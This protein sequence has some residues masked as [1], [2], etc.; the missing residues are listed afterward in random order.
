MQ[1]DSKKRIG[2]LVFSRKRP[3]FDQDWSKIV[4]TCSLGVLDHLDMGPV[5]ADA[6]VFDDPTI[7][8]ALASIQQAKCDALIIIQPS[9]ADGQFAFSIMQQWSG[10]IV[11]W[12]TPERPGDGN[13][14]SCS[15]VGAHLFA[16]IL[17]Q[18][19]HPFE[20]VYGDGEDVKIQADLARA[21]SLATTVS[22]LQRA[23][24]GVIGNHAPGFVDLAADPFLSR[25][26][27][28]I[29]QLSLSLAQYIDRVNAVS[30]ERV[31]QDVK[32]VRELGLQASPGSDFPVSEETLEISSRYYLSLGDIMSEAKLDAL[33]LQCWP[34]LP[35]VFG[36]WPY[37]A[38]SRLTAEGTSVS[39]EGDVDGA[40]QSLMSRY[41]GIG[42]GFLTDWLEHDR[43][44]IFFWHPGMAPLD[45]CH[46]IGSEEG[47][48]LGPHFNGARP[49]VV[50]GPLRSGQPVTVARLW[51][52]DGTYH[53]TAFEGVA[54]QP[55]RKVTGNSIL[56][57]VDGKDVPAR[58]DDLIHAGMP[59]HVSLYPGRSGETF[60][61]LARLLGLNWH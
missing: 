46:D 27:I 29:Q 22:R 57:E 2:V 26:G 33:S 21:I 10:P 52:C 7:R 48:T 32:R 38:V 12:A 53:L 13:V 31:Q 49:F 18:A 58:F 51:R 5:G 1:S 20:L 14:S 35:I 30:K 39:I 16:S 41:L 3:G 19:G 61:R 44:S 8:A 34:E 37:L 23:K 24:V 11:L 54:V 28:G 40:I 9:I 47:P 43:S 60:R 25:K 59:H 17:R 36:H 50:D 4:R 55:K 45:L 56:V 6:L 42:P 15:L